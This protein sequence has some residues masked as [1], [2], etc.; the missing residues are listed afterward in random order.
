[1]PLLEKLPA[2]AGWKEIPTPE[3][4]KWDKP[5]EQI[6]GVLLA[7]TVIK[8]EGK[9]VPQL[10]YALGERVI[11]CLAPYDLRQKINRG[12]I[13]CAMRVKYL[14]EDENIR[15]GPQNSPM[16][17]FSVQFKGTVNAEP[18]IHGQVITDEDIP[19]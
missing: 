10:T 13:G 1:M 14:G 16:K 17:I 2:E 11:K 3:L 4:I 9:P 15:G 7:I 18:N 12:H 8:I 6:A 5:G 19:F